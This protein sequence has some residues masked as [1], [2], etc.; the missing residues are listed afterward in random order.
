VAYVASEEHPEVTMVRKLIETS[1]ATGLSLTVTALVMVVIFPIHPYGRSQTAAARNDIVHA[2]S[3]EV[4][5]GS[6]IRAENGGVC[7][8][9]AA[10]APTSVCPRPRTESGGSACPYLNGLSTTQPCP[11]VQGYGGRS[12]ETKTRKGLMRGLLLASSA[13]GKPLPEAES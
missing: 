5:G 7:P 10:H 12:Q 11:R 9:L 8:W 13:S 2:V 6:P 4:S 1:L 3:V